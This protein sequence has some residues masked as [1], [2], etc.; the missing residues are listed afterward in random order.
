M[1]D[2]TDEKADVQLWIGLGTYFLISPLQ[3]STLGH[4]T[5]VNYAL[6]AKHSIE[7]T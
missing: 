1:T 4:P 5:R 2:R 3:H 7:A 6:I